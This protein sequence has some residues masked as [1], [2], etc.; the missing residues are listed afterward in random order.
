MT[1]MVD[2]DRL[3]IGNTDTKFYWKLSPQIYR[4]NPYSGKWDAKGWRIHTV[5]ER[6][7]VDGMLEMVRF[8]CRFV[9]VVD[10]QRLPTSFKSPGV[11]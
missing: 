7:P 6:M 4:I 10:E 11:L 8:Y 9:R 3:D 1:K 2:I 5:D